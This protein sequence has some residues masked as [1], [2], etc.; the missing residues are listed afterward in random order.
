MLRFGLQKLH[1]SIVSYTKTEME[2]DLI[3]VDPSIANCFRR[4]ILSE[5]CASIL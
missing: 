1:I 5:V 2:F 4:I 3:G